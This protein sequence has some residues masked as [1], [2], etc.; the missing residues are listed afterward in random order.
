MVAQLLTEM[1]GISEPGGVMVVGATNRPDR[2]DPA[3]LRPG[4]FD[5]VVEIPPPDTLAREKM[6]ALHAGRMP[7]Q[8]GFDAASL[9]PATE[10]FVGA[11]IAGL[12]RLAA[13]AALA[14]VGADAD[15]A[16]LRIEASDFATALNQHAEGRQWQTT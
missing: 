10:G 14:R 4:R 5:L 1:D 2:I 16:T 3:L 13:L 6:L 11:E 15:P 9:A 8:Q 7:L 12:C